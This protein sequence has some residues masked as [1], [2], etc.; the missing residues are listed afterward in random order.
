MDRRLFLSGLG[1]A[2][3]APSLGSAYAP[4]PYAPATWSELRDGSDKLVVNF[5]ASW[6]LTCQIKEDLIRQL[7]AENPD[8][9]RLTFVDVDWD[10]FGP[11]EWVQRR[12][13]VERRSTLIAFRGKKELAR[14]VNEPYERPIRKFLD[15]ALAG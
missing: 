14:L 11:S 13:K 7:V 8:Y 4:V 1:A 2:V 9:A 12:L 15:A 6:S 3:C 5:R 10:T